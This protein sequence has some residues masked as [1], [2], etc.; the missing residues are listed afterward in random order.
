MRSAICSICRST[1]PLLP[2]DDSARGFDNVAGSL[3]ISP[4]LLD[5]YNTAGAR[6]AKMAVGY[7]KSPIE[8]A[9]IAPGDTSQNEHLAGLPFG[10]RGGMAVR[11]LFAADGEYKFTVQ[12]FGLGRFVP[13]EKLLFLIDNETV[14]VRDYKGVGLGAANSADHDG[15]IEVTIPVKAGSHLVGVT[16]KA[17]NYRPS[18]DLIRHYER[19]SLEDNPIPQLQYYPAVGTM[20][21]R[22]PFNAKRP[23]DSKSLRKVYTCKPATAE[24]ETPC[25][26]EILTALMRHAYRR[27]VNADDM[28]WALGFYQQAR[29]EGTFPG[30]RR[31]GA[32]ID[33]D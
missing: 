13:N 11:H 1:R 20:R 12:N 28:E 7:W 25:A 4:T 21:I 10:T 19:K 23:D 31:T 8:A 22:G 15:E 6:I 33:P 16:F 9:Y 14:A 3:T 30:W 17:D 32:A 18:L 26:K 24:Q 5:A 2:P 29:R 27:P